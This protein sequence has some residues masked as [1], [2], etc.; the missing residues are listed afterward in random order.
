MTEE[1]IPEAPLSDEDLDLLR[2]RAARLR[3]PLQGVS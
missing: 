1:S 2:K 3:A